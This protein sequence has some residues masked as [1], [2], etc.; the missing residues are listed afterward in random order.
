MRDTIIVKGAKEHNLQNIDVDIPR[1]KLVIVTGVSGS[2]KSSLAFDTVYA[3]GQRRFLES[4]SVFAK[5][6]VSQLKKPNVDFVMGLSPVIS[7]EQKTTIRNP[8]ST[9]GTMT[10]IYDYLRMLFATIGVAH[11]PYCEGF[12]TRTTQPKRVV[13]MKS[14]EQMLEHLLALP[15]GTEVEIRAPV[16]KFYGED[17]AYLFDDVRS[18]G[19]RQVI[20]NGKSYDISKEL[21]L[22]EERT[23]QIDVVVDRFIIRSGIDKQVLASLDHGLVVGE[24]KNIADV[25]GMS[26]E[27]GVAFFS[28]QRLI[29]HK[30]GILHELGL[31]YLKKVTVSV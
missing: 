17:Y 26:I 10:D 1:N 4:L 29:A 19:H 3:E 2:G 9:V 8:R 11:C 15:E 22:D 14:A 24:G 12:D 7:I 6:F 30:L 28:D 21:E 5:K 27:E 25:L 20:I 16:F 23:Y 13:P 18:K 31:G